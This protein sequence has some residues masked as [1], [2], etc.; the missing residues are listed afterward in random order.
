MNTVTVHCSSGSTRLTSSC[1]DRLCRWGESSG[2][3][4]RQ[5]D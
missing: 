1:T 3:L 2:A 4:D 5:T